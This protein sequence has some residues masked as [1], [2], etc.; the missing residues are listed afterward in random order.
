ML[1]QQIS[2]LTLSLST[3]VCPSLTQGDGTTTDR[4]SPVAVTGGLQFS[5]I[6]AGYLHTCALVGSTGEAMCWGGNLTGQLVECVF[7]PAGTVLNR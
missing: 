7:V 3:P 2:Q 5:S 4:S 1:N 6:A